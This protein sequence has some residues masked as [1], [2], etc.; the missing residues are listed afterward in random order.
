MSLSAGSMHERVDTKI[1]YLEMSMGTLQNMLFNDGV[2][3]DVDISKF[4]NLEKLVI[5]ES[6]ITDQFMTQ[7]PKFLNL[8]CLDM[9]QCSIFTDEG[10]G[11]VKLMRSLTELD[12]SY[13]R[14]SSEAFSTLRMNPN[15]K[16]KRLNVRACISIGSWFDTI[17]TMTSL[18]YLDMGKTVYSS[19]S[20]FPKIQKL[21]SLEIL[22]M[23][24][25]HG[26]IDDSCF[27][28]ISQL[29]S[30]TYLNLARPD[31]DGLVTNDR[32]YRLKDKKKLIEINV[33]G[34]TI[35]ENVRTQLG[36]KIIRF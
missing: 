35:D 11:H 32:L 17:S 6:G 27:E 7:F 26:D 9:S 19:M 8:T 34:H 1:K 5:R 15:Q 21:Q 29:Q 10:F 16:L 24:Q 36:S 25:I 2:E 20:E 13:C 23:D 18:T 31:N 33:V 28:T 14:I 4:Q 22:Y 30:L 12:I 3:V